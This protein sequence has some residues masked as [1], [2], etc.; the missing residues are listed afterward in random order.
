M[1]II[2][3][4]GNLLNIVNGNIICI[5]RWCNDFRLVLTSDKKEVCIYQ[6]DSEKSIKKFFD[7]FKYILTINGILIDIFKNY[8]EEKRIE[9]IPSAITE[10]LK[11][12]EKW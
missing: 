9:D 12:R 5:K 10:A 1:W 11:E 8:K 7:Y 3:Q 2:C 4:N 6:T